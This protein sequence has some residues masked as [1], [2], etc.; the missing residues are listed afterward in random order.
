MPHRTNFPFKGET[1]NEETRV[2]VGVALAVAALGP[3][4]PSALLPSEPEG[5]TE[6]ELAELE[7]LELARIANRLHRRSREHLLLAVGDARTSGR[8]LHAAK[9]KVEHGKWGPWLDRNFDGSR[10]LAQIYMQLAK[11]ETVSH[12]AA[13]HD[14]A[15][16]ARGDAD[17]SWEVRQG[18]SPRRR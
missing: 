18:R 8:A 2:P 5:L 11:S 12:F 4:E 17:A 15:E 9:A 3:R 1:R 13:R 7:P 10:R 16:R 14:Y 6:D